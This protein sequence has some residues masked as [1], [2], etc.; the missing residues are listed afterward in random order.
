MGWWTR[1]KNKVANT[2]EDATDDI[3]SAP[4]FE[5]PDPGDYLPDVKDYLPDWN[6][7]VFNFIILVV[8]I[9]IIAFMLWNNL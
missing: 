7:L 9:A 6:K 2:I 3:P 4:D 8:F 1:L 5:I